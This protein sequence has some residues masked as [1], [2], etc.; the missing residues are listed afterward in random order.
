MHPDI[1]RYQSDPLY[2]YLKRQA[3]TLPGLPPKVPPRE[4]L[5]L[6][7]CGLLSFRLGIIRAELELRP[8]DGMK[9]ILERLY[10]PLAASSFGDVPTMDEFLAM[11][12]NDI[13]LWTEE[14]RKVNSGFFTW[15]DAAEKVIEKL[16]EEQLKKKGKTRHKSA[17]K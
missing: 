16:S 6:E 7:E 8:D 11:T 14:A 5:I 4:L 10:A 12:N 9:P 2:A 3:V 13:A 15:L 1:E 17:K